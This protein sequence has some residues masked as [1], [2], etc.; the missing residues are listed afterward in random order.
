MDILLADLGQ[1]ISAGNNNNILELCRFIRKDTA[2]E[3]FPVS[4]TS[5]GTVITSEIKLWFSIQRIC[6]FIDQPW[7]CSKCFKFNHP[8]LKYKSD[9]LCVTCGTQHVR[10]CSSAVKCSNSAENHCADYNQCSSHFMKLNFLAS[11][12][13]SPF[14]DARRK[15]FQK[16]EAGSYAK[17]TKCEIYG[18]RGAAKNCWILYKCYSQNLNWYFSEI[19]W[20]S[21]GI[22]YSPQQLNCE[23]YG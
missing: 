19:I 16:V 6:Q 18:S 17:V 21:C 14:V 11:K 4:V 2:R 10:Q 3:A 15:T 1:E 9:Q 5:L 13:F 20:Y 8:T 23:F 22:I 7:Q 12:A